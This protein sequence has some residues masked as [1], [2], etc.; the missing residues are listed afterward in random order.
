M[1]ARRACCAATR[2]GAGRCASS[3]SSAWRR[4]S[5]AVRIVLPA[6]IAAVPARAV[7]VPQR[8][9]R[10][11]DVR[12]T[13]GEPCG[14]PGERR[15][16]ADRAPHGG[17]SRRRGE[18]ARATPPA[19]GSVARRTCWWR[20]A[21]AAWSRSATASSSGSGGGGVVASPGDIV[22]WAG[23]AVLAAEASVAWQR[24]YAQ[25]AG[26]C[27]SRS[28]RR[29]W[30]RAGGGRR[31]HVAVTRH[32]ATNLRSCDSEGKICRRPQHSTS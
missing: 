19:R 26:C 10:L 1:N 24:Q 17:G 21:A 2:A 28:A 3:A 5:T 9:G 12:G 13:R 31:S 22:V 23:L 20:R 15:P 32:P 14:D 25:V 16:D 7:A 8:A 30:P 6:T 18:R 27:T 29:A 11:G 4:R